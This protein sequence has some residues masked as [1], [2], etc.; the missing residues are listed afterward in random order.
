MVLYNL[1]TQARKSATVTI[2]LMLSLMVSGCVSQ[3]QAIPTWPTNLEVIQLSD[4]GVC[5]SPESA[6]RLAEY[7]ADLE[8]L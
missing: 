6:R 4:G 8:S 7:R 5:L 1:S 2:L 3:S